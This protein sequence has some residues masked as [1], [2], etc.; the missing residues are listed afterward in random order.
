MISGTNIKL[1]KHIKF[2]T[3]Y[4]LDFS[5]TNYI[6]IKENGQIRKN[7]SSEYK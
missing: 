2:M 6:S 3:K 7:N 1:S 4:N 5:Y